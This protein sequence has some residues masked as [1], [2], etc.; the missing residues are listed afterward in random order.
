MNGNTL[1]Q[2]RFTKKLQSNQLKL[3]KNS[4]IFHQRRRTHNLMVIASPPSLFRLSPFNTL[5]VFQQN[6]HLR[7]FTVEY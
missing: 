3:N 1:K 7:S 4:F 5:G 6:I 2:W